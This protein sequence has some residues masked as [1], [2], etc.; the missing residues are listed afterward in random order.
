MKV[1]LEVECWGFPKLQRN[2]LYGAVTTDAAPDLVELIG[3]PG[4][5][6]QA[7]NRMKILAEMADERDK[8]VVYSYRRLPGMP[9]GVWRPDDRYQT[10]L[11]ALA[12]ERPNTWVGVHRMTD[13]AAT[14]VNVGI[15]WQTPAGVTVLSLLNNVGPHIST[16]LQRERGIA[17][18]GQLSLWH[19]WADPRRLPGPQQWWDTLGDL[20]DHYGQVPCLVKDGPN[21]VEVDLSPGSGSIENLYHLG[22]MWLLARPKVNPQGERYIE[23]RLLG[24]I[25]PRTDDFK[26]L[27]TRLVSL[28]SD[29]VACTQHG[30]AKADAS[31]L[32]SDLRQR[33]HDYLPPQ[34]LAWQDWERCSAWNPPP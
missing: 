27:V 6:E 20:E 2:S 13:F 12:Q 11:D 19:G 24:S 17:H 25:D 23:I 7:I 33:G 15:D 26:Y 3:N 5:L 31:D 18:T 1:G 22:T 29:L 9:D 32:L 34:L 14:H 21:G 10:V 28:V 16:E 8:P 30:C 4:C